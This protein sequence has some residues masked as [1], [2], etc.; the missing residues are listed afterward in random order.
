[1]NLPA[2]FTR[3]ALDPPVVFR[4]PLSLYDIGTNLKKIAEDW[5]ESGMPNELWEIGITN[6]IIEGEWDELNL[7]WGGKTN[8]V[9]NPALF[10]KIVRLRDAG[11]EVTARFGRGTFQFFGL[12]LLLTTP[13]QAILMESGPIRWYFVAASGAI[14]LALLITGRSTTPL[15]KRYLMKVVEQATRHKAGA[16]GNR[17]LS[18]PD[19][20]PRLSP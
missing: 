11:S 8:P 17:T 12:I 2:I 6:L 1:M 9:N 7:E 13:F 3:V 20:V 4:T 5:R 19:T 10:V 14:S 16:R 15:L 18:G